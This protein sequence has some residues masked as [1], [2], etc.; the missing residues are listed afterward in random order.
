M[1]IV[2][3]LLMENKSLN[4]KLTMNVK[5]PNQFCLGIFSNRLGALESRE[6]SL[7]GH[8]YGFSVDYDFC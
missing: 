1:I 2:I 8:V 7:N 3:C 4:L 5:F 6:V